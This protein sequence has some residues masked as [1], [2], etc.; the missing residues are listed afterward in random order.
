MISMVGLKE[1][2]KGYQ[3]Q[4]VICDATGD[5]EL[6]RAI[7]PQIEA[8]KEPWP[9]LPRPESVRVSQVVDRTLSKYAVAVESKTHNKQDL[10]RKAEGARRMYAAVLLKALQ[11]DGADVG[12]ITYKSTKEWINANCFVP[13]WIKLAHHG[14]VTGTNNFRDVRALFEVGR[15]QPPPQALAWQAE[16]LFS[17]H[18]GQREY[19]KEK[20]LIPIVPDKDGY[21]HIEVATY[22]FRD[23]LMRKMLWQAR[24]GGSIQNFGRARAGLRDASSPL[25][26]HRWTDRT[27]ASGTRALARKSISAWTA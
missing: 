26:I 13:P 4:T 18:I 3:V 14:G 19:G 6:L 17:N 27:R 15:N 1:L 7:W 11:Y 22:H 23:P 24:E 25:D 9:Q 20:A 2:T 21:T 8:E 16:A 5:V 12:V 10:E